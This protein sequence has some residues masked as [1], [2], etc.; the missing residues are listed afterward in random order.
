M[1]PLSTHDTIRTFLSSPA[2]HSRP[3]ACQ[4]KMKFEQFCIE[5][6]YV[7]KVFHAIYKKFLTAID[8][9]DYHP[10]QQ[11]TA[12][13]TRVKRSSMYICDG[14]YHSQMREL[15]PSEESFLD[16]FMKAL[17]KINPSLHNNLSC[18]KRTDIFTW[19]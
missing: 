19:L 5:I 9:I 14:Q 16:A 17:Y 12:N 13:T 2:C 6:N 15:T 7:Y 1:T 8:H 11:V 4:A 18:M 10:S 3:H